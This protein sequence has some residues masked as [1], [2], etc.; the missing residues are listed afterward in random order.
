MIKESDKISI[1]VAIY[2]VAQ[3]LEQCIK[4]L[5]EQ[6]Y[7]NIEIILVDDGST[8]GSG[9]ICDR[10]KGMDSRIQVSH[11]EN[12]G[13]SDARNTGISLSHG[14]YLMF[15]DGDDWVSR[16]FCKEALKTV[17]DGSDIGVFHYCIYRKGESPK[18][19]Q[20]A[21][22]GSFER[23]KGLYKLVSGATKDY[24]WNKIYHK[25]L[26]SQIRY[27]IGYKY[28]DMGTTYKL[29]MSAHRIT[30]IST[31]LYFYRQR[32]GSIMSNPLKGDTIDL[33]ELLLERYQICA[34]RYAQTEKVI[35]DMLVLAALRS[36]FNHFDVITEMPQYHIIHKVLTK[37]KS[38]PENAN[39]PEKMMLILYRTSEPLFYKMSGLIYKIRKIIRFCRGNVCR[40]SGK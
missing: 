30:F 13:L 39:L 20:G 34:S 24:A 12:G 27:P 26:F 1:I 17:S 21:V 9:A 7:K 2:N 4:S 33:F 29:F 18:P 6:S 8:D 15:V 14:I 32:E 35:W 11:K 37:N 38:V 22:E 36:S 23:E 10:W 25:E 19:A 3:Y 5:V 40:R 16:D 31:P 28:E